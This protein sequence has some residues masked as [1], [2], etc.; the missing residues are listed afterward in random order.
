MPESISLE[1]FLED[2]N[3]HCFV[4][5]NEKDDELPN[6]TTNKI[7]RTLKS[8]LGREL[9]K[10]EY[11]IFTIFTGINKHTMINN[12]TIK[13]GNVT[14]GMIHILYR[15]FRENGDKN[16][17]RVEYIDIIKIA[18]ILNTVRPTAINSKRNK[19]EY[20]EDGKS[21]ILITRKYNKKSYTLQSFYSD[22][23][24]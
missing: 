10:D 16:G 3:A 8:K 13:A 20:V 24:C 14:Q 15:H 2:Q 12:V 22:D 18:D 11:K 19:Y 9:T 5:I 1:N 21:Y 23:N 17:G 7:K 6:E 4:Y